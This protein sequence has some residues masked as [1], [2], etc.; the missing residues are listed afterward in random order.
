MISATAFRQNLTFTRGNKEICE[1]F[2]QENGIEVAQMDRENRRVQPSCKLFVTA[3]VTSLCLQN[4]GERS[5]STR[6]QWLRKGTREHLLD[7]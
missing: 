7:V 5:V 4:T 3:V 2:E 6:K 1:L